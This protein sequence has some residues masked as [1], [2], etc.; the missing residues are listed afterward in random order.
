MTVT[1]LLWGRADVTIQHGD[2]IT[3]FSVNTQTPPQ[4]KRSNEH[5][6]RH[7]AKTSLG[8]ARPLAD[9]WVEMTVELETE[10]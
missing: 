1:G 10:G 2:M 7:V 5:G 4:S 9:H 6:R 3:S 8:H